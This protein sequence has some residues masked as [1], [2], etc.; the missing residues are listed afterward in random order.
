MAKKWYSVLVKENVY[1]IGSQVLVVLAGVMSTLLFPRILGPESFGYFSLVFA[2]ANVFIF[3][4]ELGLATAVMKMIPVS[5]VRKDTASYYRFFLRIKYVLT[6]LSSFALFMLAD[7]ISLRFFK[8]PE[9]ASGIRLSSLF[10]FSY[11]LIYTFY[12][13]LFVATK[14]NKFSF[15]VNVVFQSSRV[16]LPLLLYYFY[17][18]YTS[19]ILGLG[20]A[21]S[22]GLIAG[23]LFRRNV[24]V[25]DEGEGPLDYATLKKYVF[26][27]MLWSLGSMLLQWIDSIVVG[28][29]VSPTDVG[30]YRIGVM[31]IS[32]VWLFI[33][34]SS[35][36]LFALYSE[37]TETNERDKINTVYRYSLRYSMIISSLVMV[38]IWLTSG[39][40]IKFIYG[41]AYAAAAPVLLIFSLLAIEVSLNTINVPLLQ[42]I[43][44]IDLQTKYM[45]LVGLLTALGSIYASRY[46]INGV[47]FAVMCIRIVSIMLL[48]LYVLR[49][50]K[51]NIDVGVYAKP[52]VSA[53]ITLLVLHPFRGIVTSLPLGILY[54]FSVVFVYGLL[55]VVFRAV[56]AEEVGKIFSAL[57]EK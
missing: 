3:F 4:S 28:V 49:N 6:I 24:K 16:A 40:F 27:G 15:Y 8:H 41:E 14:R 39:Y 12:D 33:P 23:L 7:Y 26:Y 34:V 1:G 21:A 18:S 56:S 46:G 36:V 53:V 17:R 45:V 25:L 29:Y 44:K 20:L 11:S 32:V 9:L 13:F 10:L 30:I 54:A 35:G 42:G 22:L 48:T 43:G 5:I 37:K 2:L 50:I 51:L 55:L 19:F 52:L 47:A 31:L 57:R 38:G